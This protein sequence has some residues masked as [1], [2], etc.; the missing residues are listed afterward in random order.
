V[1]E[2]YSKTL[3]FYTVKK[4][5]TASE[6]DD[7]NNEELD[8]LKKECKAMMRYIKKLHRQE[9]DLRQRNEMIARE[10]LLC[11]FQPDALEPQPP[12]QRRKQAHPASTNK[13]N[14]A[15]TFSSS[16]KDDGDST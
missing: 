7:E 13:S 5:M 14:T 9:K 3:T 1:L 11:G 6:L 12:K 15:T 16:G 4:I 2:R 8:R 10:A